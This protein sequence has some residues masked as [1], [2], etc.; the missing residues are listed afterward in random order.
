MI[1]EKQKPKRNKVN[2]DQNFS[3]CKK[4]LTNKMPL[5]KISSLKSAEIKELLSERGLETE[6]QKNELILRLSQLVGADVI[7]FSQTNVQDQIN[8]L[9]E[10]FAS[11]MQ[12]MQSGSNSTAGAS[13]CR[14]H[15]E[16]VGQETPS[17]T[18]SKNNYS[19]KEIAEMIPD[20]DPT[21]EASITVEQFVDRVNS[22]IT[23]YKW[24]EKCLV[25]AVYSRLKGTA[26][27]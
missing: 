9:R 3:V 4:T 7:K 25:L 10:M 5:V 19:V 27:I 15:A 6:G 21:N 18:S 12:L 17:V 26:K 11:V 13:G 14:A 16:Q 1:S 22:A 2:A 8:E 20:F 24:E 23:A